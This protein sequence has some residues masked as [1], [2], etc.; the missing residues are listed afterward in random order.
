MKH[1]HA[2]RGQESPEYT[3][4]ASLKHRCNS[5]GNTH[6]KYYGGRG[7]R[8]CDRWSKSF[9]AFLEDMGLRP[10]GMAIERID[11][12]GDYEPGNC[13]WATR[14]EQSLNRRGAVQLTHNGETLTQSAWAR[15]IGVSHKT[16]EYWL[17]RDLTIA[18][19]CER[20][21]HAE[22]TT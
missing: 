1:G 19:I 22:D 7:I 21:G 8:V 10:Q 6:Y 3:T 20:F 11:N 12:D 4:W 18:E 16:V 14:A 17:K 13:R 2:M 5:P 15:R 9:I